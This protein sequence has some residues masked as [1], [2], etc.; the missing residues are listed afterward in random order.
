MSSSPSLKQ[1]AG[2][3][4]IVT[5]AS[6]GIGKAIADLLV[7][8]GVI[9]AGL[10]R[11]VQLVQEHAKELMG[12]KGSLHAFQCDLSKQEETVATFQKVTS[13]LGPVSVLVNNAGI[14]SASGILDGE[15]EKWASVTNTNV[16]AV[17]L[18]TREAVK[19]MKTNNI[20]GYIINVNSV[21]GHM[22]PDFPKMGLYP[23]SKH[24]VTALTETIRL[25]INREKLP[26]RITSISPGYVETEILEVAFGKISKGTEWET[27]Q[28]TGLKD[29]DIADAV[30]YVLSTPE[31]V[32]VK[33]LTIT[34]QGA[35]LAGIARRSERVRNHAKELSG[36]KGVLHAF[37]CSLTKEDQILSTFKKI[38]TYRGPFS[39]LVK[40]R[41]FSKTCECSRDD[42]GLAMSSSL[43]CKNIIKSNNI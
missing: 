25:E 9:V 6:A 42:T 8:H 18:C 3:V 7:K 41:A 20:K 29:K 24:A 43:T 1:F 27:V 30:F 13:S 23:P 34:R 35:Q 33:E 32:N 36:E 11:R 15:V 38:T 17:A 21:A 22:V 19:I 5:G 12:E 4:A 16:I 10:A 39:V 37:Q 14:L 26:I 31:H 28:E 2:K 40:M